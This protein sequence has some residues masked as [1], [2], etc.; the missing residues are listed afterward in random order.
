M[1]DVLLLGMGE[2][3]GDTLDRLHAY[4]RRL[5]GRVHYVVLTRGTAGVGR[6]ERE[7]QLFVYPTRS[8]S[9][10]HGARDAAR[11]ALDVCRRFRPAVVYAQDPFITAWVG[12]LLRR[13][14]GTPLVVGNHSSFLDNPRWIAERPIVF[15]ALNRAA[16]WVIPRADALRV[17]NRTE[18]EKYVRR[19]GVPAERITVL[20]TPARVREFAFFEDP[21]QIAALRDRLG[22]PA[23]A[24]VLVWVGRPARVKRVPVLLEVLR[25]VR[26]RRPRAH[27]LLVGDRAQ[28][29]EDLDAALDASG[30]RPHV[31]WVDRG[32]PH[33]ELPPYYRLGRVYVHASHYEGLCKVVIEAAA[34]GLPVV[35]TDVGGTRELVDP[36]RTG[37]LA[38]VDDA[39]ALADRVV[40]LLEDPARAEAMGRA[41]RQRML[42]EYDRERAIDTFVDML[43]RAAEHGREIR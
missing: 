31:T 23:D 27:L 22:I 6:Q 3:T 37:W 28:A 19:L 16:R 1:N 5:P 8:R 36:G 13:R 9:V 41:G 32:V 25:R 38:P 43:R 2:P 11:L 40:E 42:D 21:G 24:E 14:T 12:M 34:S 30:V 33:G 7:G 10:L 29:Q 15:R 26:Q 4:A 35:A 39:G 20:G 18:G 17:V